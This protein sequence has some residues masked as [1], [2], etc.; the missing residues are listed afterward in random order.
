MCFGAH[1]FSKLPFGNIFLFFISAFTAG[2]CLRYYDI[3]LPFIIHDSIKLMSGGGWRVLASIFPFH[4][5]TIH[6]TGLGALEYSVLF[7]FF[8]SP[9][10]PCPVGPSSY[11]AIVCFLQLGILYLR[12][13]PLILC[14]SNSFFFFLFLFG[15]RGTCISE[16]V[17]G[18]FSLYRRFYLTSICT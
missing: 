3:M 4:N 18:W 11:P 12:C 15:R 14:F 1:L 5:F 6:V 10:F 13:D 17:M 16:S 8:S 7:C 2:L 9:C